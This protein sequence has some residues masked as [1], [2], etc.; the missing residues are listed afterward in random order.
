[1]NQALK[2]GATLIGLYLVVFYGSNSGNLIKAGASGAKDVVQ[3]FQGQ[4]R[5]RF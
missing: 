2:Y 5:G 3:A 4:A 1:M